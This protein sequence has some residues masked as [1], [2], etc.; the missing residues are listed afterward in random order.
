MATKTVTIDT[1]EWKYPDVSGILH[2]VTNA[3]T[4]TFT[5]TDTAATNVP[6]EIDNNQKVTTTE[7]LTLYINQSET[8]RIMIRA[9]DTG[10]GTALYRQ[11][12]LL[13]I[14]DPTTGVVQYW[15]PAIW[16]VDDADAPTSIT[17]TFEDQYGNTFSWAGV[18]VA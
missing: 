8:E 6:Y 14:Q 3:Q 11:E 2:T 1:G 17:A 13:A 9:S 4:F 7:G 12:G 10:E 18:T 5:L 15:K 16:N